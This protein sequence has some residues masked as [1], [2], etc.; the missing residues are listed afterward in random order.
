MYCYCSFTLSLVTHLRRIISHYT[1]G[2][3][4]KHRKNQGFLIF[5]AST[6]M[7]N[8]PEIEHQNSYLSLSSIFL[9][10]V[11]WYEKKFFF[12]FYSNNIKT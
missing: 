6:G 3:T 7:E 8:Y 2:K 10:A 12:S 4:S 11:I 9:F 1:P 5:P